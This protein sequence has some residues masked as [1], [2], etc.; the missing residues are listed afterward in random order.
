MKRYFWLFI[1]SSLFGAI[2]TD[3]FCCVSIAK[4]GSNLTT[5]AIRLLTGYKYCQKKYLLPDGGCHKHRNKCDRFYFTHFYP[6]VANDLHPKMNPRE[7]PGLKYV[8]TVRDLRDVLV[9]SSRYWPELP[10]T[11]TF[12]SIYRHRD[13]HD[14]VTCKILAEL[15][16]EWIYNK[17][18]AV[19][20]N[21]D[22]L[23][24]TSFYL[25]DTIRDIQNAVAW[26]KRNKEVND[27][28]LV[29]HYEDL[30][31]PKG[32]GNKERQIAALKKIA[33][34]LEVDLS[35]RN[36]ERTAK[37]LYGRAPTFM[38]GKAGK[39]KS[40]FSEEAT[41]KFWELL[42]DEMDYLGYSE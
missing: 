23:L 7:N 41:E 11:R 13:L 4:S 2:S 6:E 32:G 31:G 42:T 16:E 22:L 38:V 12:G 5:R 19:E 15:N 10:T 33:A 8:V 18:H 14:E 40:Y 3:D 9:S 25:S 29:V 34:F 1:T 36:L 24:D 21:V 39:Y 27:R 20:K 17:N 30:V 26:L 35:G 28:I 37:F